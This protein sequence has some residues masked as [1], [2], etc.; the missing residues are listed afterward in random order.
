MAVRNYDQTI[1]TMVT[2]ALD[3]MSR[4][5]Q[6][7]LTDSGEKF[8]KAA[9]SKGR[10]FVVN[11]AENVRHPVLYDHGEST[12]YYDPDSLGTTGNLTADATEI[13]TQCLFTMQAATRNINFPQSQPAG[14]MIDY[15]SNVV[16]ANMMKILNE[17]ECLFVRGE[18]TGSGTEA[19]VVPFSGDTGYSGN[20]PMS[21]AALLHTGSDT[22]TQV[23]G[24]L[25][26]DAINVG[27]ANTNWAT[28][29][30]AS[31]T[32]TGGVAIF[33]DIQ[34]MILQSGFS[35][36]ERPT[37]FYC[38]QTFYEFFLAQMRKL[39]ALPDPVQANLG[40]ESA[41]PF[42]GITIDWSRYL[43]KDEIWDKTGSSAMHPVFG[44]NWN[45]LRLNLVR[46]GGISGDSLGFIR[47]IGDTQPH[48]LK[49]N[50]FKRIE[51]KR[52]W[53]LDGGRRSFVNLNGLT[54]TLATT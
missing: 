24:N 50:I 3:T 51:W 45:S 11:D 41:I 25:R 21:V 49:T 34:K 44:I 10:L 54:G 36:V 1:D 32:T 40:R 15:V 8:L 23:F 14:N 27:T 52:Q 13:L 48:P 6:N 35:E 53:S 5:P 19:R 47:T 29:Q 43:E 33:T 31:S 16:K 7:L 30:V 12:T 22:A 26:S 20:Q 4:D 18:N 38:S 2:T 17:E 9:A 37:D 28:Q 46:S 39:G 42:G